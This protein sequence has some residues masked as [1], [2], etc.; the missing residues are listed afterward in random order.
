MTTSPFSS[1]LSEYPQLS[2][3][4]STSEHD[5]PSTD[6]RP[7]CYSRLREEQLDRG[8]DRP[9]SLVSTLS[10]GSSRDG[11]SLFGSNVALP[12]SS[13]PPIQSEE[14]IALELSPAEGNVE[15]ARENSPVLIGSRGHW[16]E[17]LEPRVISNQ[18]NNN[19]ATSNRKARAEIL[20]IPASPVVTDTMAPNPKLTYVDRVVMEIIETERMYV[21][22]LRSIVEVR[23]C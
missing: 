9:V 19:N 23:V 1:H 6:L 3:P 15:Q 18:W 7:V 12:S 11:H 4:L 10:S 14:D 13:T 8:G 20:H 16:Q 17:Q 5:Q 22:D 2:S 21:Q